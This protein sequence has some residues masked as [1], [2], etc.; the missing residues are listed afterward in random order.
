M[1]TA[2]EEGLSPQARAILDK[3]RSRLRGDTGRVA[4]LEQRYERLATEARRV[5]DLLRKVGEE[6]AWRDRS[7]TDRVYAWYEFDDLRLLLGEVEKIAAESS[8]GGR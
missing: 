7:Q 4:E 5:I 8:E 6:T 2:E 3:E 1:K